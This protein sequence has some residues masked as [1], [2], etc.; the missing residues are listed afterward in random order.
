ME[1]AIRGSVELID[2]DLDVVVSGFLNGSFNFGSFNGN[3]SHDGNGN[4]NH[5][6]NFT[7]ARANGNAKR[8]GP[9]GSCPRET[10]TMIRASCCFGLVRGVAV[11]SNN[12]GRAALPTRSEI[13]GP[14]S[15]V[16]NLT[17][18]TVRN[19]RAP[20]PCRGH[21]RLPSRMPVLTILLISS[22]TALSPAA[23]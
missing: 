21:A 5:S 10:T 3:G 4:G 17:R 19:N 14:L 23:S 7:F 22:T 13:S 12:P 11:S 6:G 15:I 1:D 2:A 16:P 20:G 18:F 8:V 9:A